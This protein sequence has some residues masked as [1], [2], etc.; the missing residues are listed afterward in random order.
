MDFINRKPETEKESDKSDEACCS[1]WSKMESRYHPLSSHPAWQKRHRLQGES[2]A[3]LKNRNSHGYASICALSCLLIMRG[4]QHAKKTGKTQKRRKKAN[5]LK[6]NSAPQG[7]RL[8][9]SI[10]SGR[11]ERKMQWRED[12]TERRG[13]GRER[14]RKRRERGRSDDL[15][16]LSHFLQRGSLPLEDWGSIHQSLPGRSTSDHTWR[17]HEGPPAFDQALESRMRKR[18]EEKRETKDNKKKR[19]TKRYWCFLSPSISQS[20]RGH[21]TSNHKLHRHEEALAFD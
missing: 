12:T 3:S 20:P 17:R 13:G 8:N 4:D 5:Q 14:R 11:W 7:V 9:P 1:Y 16:V 2:L 6:T 18:P 19:G 21:L 10:V 15:P